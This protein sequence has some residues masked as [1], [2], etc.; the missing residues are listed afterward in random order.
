MKVL[1]VMASCSKSSGVAQVMMNYY[2]KIKDEIIFDFLMFWDFEESFT[3]EILEY[4][5]KVFF[6]GKPTIKSLFHYIKWLEIFFEET[7]PQYDAVHLHELYLNPIILPI[8]KKHGIKVLIA[9]SHTTR[10]SDKKM[11][12]IRNAILFYPVRFF[13]TNYFACSY[14]AGV[15][16]YGRK[17]SN[18]K[19]FHIIRN[20]IEC[21]RYVYSE[22]LRKEIRDELVLENEYVIG[23]IGRF[24]PQ[25]NHS[26]LL[27]M[28]YELQIRNA[29][30]RLLLVGEGTL[31]EDVKRKAKE[32][33]ISEKVIFSGFRTDVTALLSAM[34]AFVLPSTFEGLGI[35]LIEAQCNGLPCIAS[36]RVPREADILSSFRCISL[37]CNPKEWAEEI[38]E[39]TKERDDKAR[40]MV[41]LA[42]YEINEQ[43]RKLLQ[44]YN[45]IMQERNENE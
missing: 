17:I 25:K 18:S 10:F 27:D 20:A 35:V 21:E 28:F 4:G 32:L 11:N 38:L 40:E 43:A 34:D 33:G 2:R 29:N 8:A 9:H 26:F 13:A 7:V 42:G 5:G 24:A 45:I 6:T 31:Y 39:C 37:K 22:Q 23:H 41:A 15:T 12:G 1:Q 16:A 36:D 30:A 44:L 19:R 14:D 3:D